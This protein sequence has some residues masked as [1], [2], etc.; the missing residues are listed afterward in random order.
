MTSISVTHVSAD[1]DKVDADRADTI[2]DKDLT[3][4][5]ATPTEVT[6]SSE[7][8][9]SPPPPTTTPNTSL[10]HGIGAPFVTTT[11]ARNNKRGLD[12]KA[13]PKVKSM[14][15]FE[16]VISILDYL[17]ILF[18]TFNEIEK[19]FTR[20][21]QTLADKEKLN[22]IKQ[23]EGQQAKLKDLHIEFGNETKNLS[24][25]ESQKLTRDDRR[26][27]NEGIDGFKFDAGRLGER[28]N[29]FLSANFEK[30]KLSETSEKI[31][32]N[33]DKAIVAAED[34]ALSF[35]S[36]I[37]VNQLVGGNSDSNDQI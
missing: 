14:T 22:L 20:D 37:A 35:D 6:L 7:I 26:K 33:F 21:H 12:T 3:L 11:E 10:V 28:I 31:V 9:T 29:K 24:A 13:I 34:L 23:V 5:N 30:L 36:N 32:K 18:T 15:S 2:A 8:H 16:K 1:R 25:K 27:L 4:A 19:K 17:S